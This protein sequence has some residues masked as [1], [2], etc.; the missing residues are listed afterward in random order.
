MRELTSAFVWR[1]R[2]DHTWHLESDAITDGG[3]CCSF[4]SELPLGMEGGV[5]PP[6]SRESLPN[7]ELA[8]D[9][10]QHIVRINRTDNVAEMFEHFTQLD[11][12]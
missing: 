9:A 1:C 2:E 10:I 12:H 8:E 5:K 4:V 7:T 11:D 6:H 3:A